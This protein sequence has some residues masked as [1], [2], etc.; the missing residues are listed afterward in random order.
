VQGFEDA[1]HRV[2][3]VR[4][5][6]PGEAHLVYAAG[7]RPSRFH[8]VRGTAVGAGER[9][10]RLYQHSLGLSREPGQLLS[11]VREIAGRP[12]GTG[13]SA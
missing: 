2:V 10:V 1:A 4:R 11:A 6:G 8:E 3:G 13:S 9:G 12:A 7:R 5:R